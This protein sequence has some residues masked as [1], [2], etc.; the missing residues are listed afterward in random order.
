M[1]FRP[2]FQRVQG[3]VG[4][5]EESHRCFGSQNIPHR[6]IHS[7]NGHRT[8]VH[9][10]SGKPSKWIVP[11]CQSLMHSVLRR[12][13]LMLMYSTQNWF[14]R[15]LE[16]LPK[17]PQKFFSWPWNTLQS[18][19][20]LTFS[21]FHIKQI[22]KTKPPALV[23]PGRPRCACSC[24]PPRWCWAA[25]RRHRLPR[26]RGWWARRRPGSRWLRSRWSVTWLHRNK[27]DKKNMDYRRRDLYAKVSLVL[28]SKYTSR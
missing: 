10:S 7:C 2:F 11:E 26:S 1:A 28:E 12:S 22:K 20:R 6:F 5:C 23:A 16:I 27:W 21:T 14:L 24:P 17:P 4:I 19:T 15:G 13:Y 8:I 9:L 18:S 25:P 3:L